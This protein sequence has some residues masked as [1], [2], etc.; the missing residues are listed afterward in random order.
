[1]ITFITSKQHNVQA[2]PEKIEI[3]DTL[4]SQDVDFLLSLP[5]IGFDLETN[6]LDPYAGD[7]LLVILGDAS[8]QYVIDAEE[9]WMNIITLLAQLTMN[10]RIWIGANTKF[11]YSFLKAKYSISIPKM[12]DVMICEQRL[13]QGV[14]Y[15]SDQQNKKVPIS[16]ALDEIIK[17]RLGFV[18]NTMLSDAIR[19]TFINSNP[20]TFVF[21]NRH[22][23]YAAGDITHLFDV[24]IKQKEAIAKHNLGFLAYNIEL[25]LIR[26]LADAE[27]EGVDILDDK[28][29]AIVDTNVKKR[30]DY[31]CQLDEELRSLRDTFCFPQE[32]KYFSNGK[33][34]RKRQPPQKVTQ[35][36]LFGSLFEEIDVV[37][38]NKRK[39]GKP[40]VKE[41]YVNYSS[42]DQ[43]I[44]IFGRLK[45]PLPAENRFKAG[46]TEYVI[47]SFTEHNK[48]DKSAYKFTTGA[49]AIESYLN[50]NPQTP[51]RKFIE[52]LIEY[53]STCTELDTFGEAFLTKFRNPVTK[54]FHTIFRQASS[55]TGRLQSGDKRAN[56][57][58]CQ[59][60]PAKKSFREAFVCEEGWEM[61]T[62]DLSGAEAVIMIDKARDEKFYQM[63]IVN[64]DAHSPLA[65]AVWNAIGE[66]RVKN[67]IKSTNKWMSK[68]TG[69]YFSKE[70]YE[71][72]SIVISKKENSEIRTE[73]KNV[74]F[75][76]IYG[77]HYKKVA[78]MLNISHEEAKI[79]LAVMKGII[80]KTFKMVEGNA[81]FALENGYLILNTRTNARIW[82]KEVLD[83]KRNN[84]DID[85]SDK[86]DIEGSARNA[87]IQGTQAD[88]VKE[89]MVEIGR[90]IREQNL[91]AKLVFQV[92][93]E[94]VYKYKKDCPEVFIPTGM[95][96]LDNH[97]S[98]RLAT[99]DFAKG[100]TENGYYIPFNAYVK[101]KMIEVANRYL[102]FIKMSAEQH[103][104]NSWTK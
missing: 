90:T 2:E 62:T 18:P 78:K 63:A 28:W 23:E 49:G 97:M 59:N 79:C 45:Q 65:T 9:N 89:M 75:A 42:T 31:Q 67:G 41:A 73:F 68:T 66:Y 32:R 52:T 77:A 27:L 58:N 70:S 102:S 19:N 12:Y 96:P 94:L 6:S 100:T 43:L 92:H 82:Y 101:H 8:H 44:Y 29:L 104:G 51:I 26:E 25:P 76:A 22:I 72:M 30:Y 15:W 47:P 13:V 10:E 60:I 37:V 24:R 71:L 36:N 34:D 11:D 48:I 38:S 103:V 50:E 91:P 87:P 46:T 81:K 99:I 14:T 57:F 16:C 80:P 95:I 84:S 4:S 55:L 40:K 7:I 1:M 86:H 39:K 5:I 53:R 61:C 17:R 20:K 98:M 88:M 64:D 21:D 54:K 85:W 74:T 83:A 93:D 33:W 69:E 35:D 3:R 56:R